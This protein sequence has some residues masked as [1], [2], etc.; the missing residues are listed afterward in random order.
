MSL[1]ETLA[2]LADKAPALRHQAASKLAELKQHEQDYQAMG[3][4]HW[5]E[6]LRLH[7]KKLRD[8]ATDLIAKADAA[9]KGWFRYDPSDIKCHTRATRRTTEP[10]QARCG[11]SSEPARRRQ[12]KVSSCGRRASRMGIIPIFTGSST[13]WPIAVEMRT[14][15]SLT[16]LIQP[17]NRPE[18]L[19]SLPRAS[20]CIG[21][22]ER[23]GDDVGGDL[24]GFIVNGLA[25]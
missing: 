16:G 25:G 2:R 8:E 23:I 20:Q 6:G 24:E 11:K 9:E 17:S 19:S 4:A 1:T 12:R 21:G 15:R 7:R 3:R 10:I 18:F 22:Q 14:L 13:H 5:D